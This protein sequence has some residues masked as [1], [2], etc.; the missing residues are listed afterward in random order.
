MFSDRWD[1]SN[2]MKDGRVLI[3]RDP[4]IFKYILIYLINGHQIPKIKDQNITNKIKEEFNFWNIQILYDSKII[5][6]ETY[7]FIDEVLIDGKSLELLY[8]GSVD[9][10]KASDFHNKCDDIADTLTVI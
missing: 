1:Q 2:L 7:E 10:F 3:D 6:P 8:R 5:L 4:S 9:G